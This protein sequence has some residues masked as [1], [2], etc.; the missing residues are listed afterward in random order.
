MALSL[1]KVGQLHVG[2][3][4]V[5]HDLAVEALHVDALKVGRHWRLALAFAP[6]LTQA[7]QS[8]LVAVGGAGPRLAPRLLQELN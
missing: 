6:R 5:R 2:S 4:H 7:E 3:K 1:R 8:Q